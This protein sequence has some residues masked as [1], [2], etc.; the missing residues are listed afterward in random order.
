MHC[1]KAFRLHPTKQHGQASRWP[2]SARCKQAH[3]AKSFHAAV[4]VTSPKFGPTNLLR[5]RISEVF[6]EQAID[7]SKPHV[8]P[9][10]RFGFGLQHG[11]AAGN[12]VNTPGDF[13]PSWPV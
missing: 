12:F 13:A 5:L 1:Q 4:A 2:R 11:F 9:V 3:S 6:L 8:N 10:S 7:G